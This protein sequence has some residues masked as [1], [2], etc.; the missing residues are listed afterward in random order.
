MEG[1]KIDVFYVNEDGEKEAIRGS[2]F[3]ATH[4]KSFPVKNNELSG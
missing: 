1:L 3:M 4:K 2:P